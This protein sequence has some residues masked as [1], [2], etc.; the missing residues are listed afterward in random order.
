MTFRLSVVVLAA[1]VGWGSLCSGY[2]NA[3]GVATGWVIADEGDFASDIMPG[4]NSTSVFAGAGSLNTSN[5]SSSPDGAVEA[6]ASFPNVKVKVDSLGLM[7][8]Q[9]AYGAAYFGDSITVLGGTG[10]FELTMRWDFDGGVSG[11]GGEYWVNADPE[12]GT[13]SGSAAAN[14]RVFL[15][16]FGHSALDLTQTDL[17]KDVALEPS[18]ALEVPYYDPFDPEGNLL[19]LPGANSV[20]NFV[21]EDYEDGLPSG[22]FVEAWYTD[23]NAIDLAFLG[24][25]ASF[26]WEYGVPLEFGVLMEGWASNGGAVDFFNTGTFTE[27]VLPAG[28]TLVSSG[29]GS[30]NVSS[31]PEP[32]GVAVMGLAMLGIS[33]RRKRKS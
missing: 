1:L 30:Y 4:E 21:F 20:S 15:E 28:A 26:T 10:S 31:V 2:A 14:F 27:I 29:G 13:R 19:N 23:E 3:Q 16:P 6:E 22:E 12:I 8:D 11:D 24:G 7:S 32:S 17:F 5:S 25:G 9:V 18:G 33:F